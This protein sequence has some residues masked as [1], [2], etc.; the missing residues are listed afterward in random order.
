MIC[1]SRGV[2]RS[3]EVAGRWGVGLVSAVVV[4]DR[5]PEAV[6]PARGR[7]GS[8]IPQIPEDS[9]GKWK[10]ARQARGS[11]SRRAARVRG[12]GK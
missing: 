8:K 11:R 3:V 9:R 5:L 6:W 4:C 12:L 10:C 2:S 7:F 1:R